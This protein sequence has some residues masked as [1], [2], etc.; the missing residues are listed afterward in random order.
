M[1]REQAGYGQRELSKLL[2]WSSNAQ[3]SKYESGTRRPSPEVLER[4]LD[5]L[6]VDDP[7]RDQ[8]LAT[9]RRNG[10]G[11]LMA[12][13]PST[14]WHLAQV[15]G[16]ERVAKR[17]TDI[18]PMMIPGLL[19]TR[20]YARIVLSEGHTTA[21]GHPDTERRVRIRMERAEIITRPEDPVQFRAILHREGLTAP[22]AP[23]AVMRDQLRHLLEM[24][25]RP[26]VTIQVV[27]DPAPGWLPSHVGPFM[28][29]E[30]SETPT[31]VYLEHYRTG[32]FLWEP[33]DVRSFMAAA[34]RIVQAAMTPTRTVELIAEIVKEPT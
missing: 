20:D 5:A 32:A 24:T 23:P 19:Q 9:V 2:G 27:P 25:D 12:G 21:P 4:I 3:L 16:Y 15:L 1:L 29:L 6:D 13:V 7:E 11:E 8:L 18:S 28:L 10:L 26:N 31:L 17:I 22:F 34:E 14:G 30:F 33:E